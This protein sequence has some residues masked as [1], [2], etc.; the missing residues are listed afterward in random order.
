MASHLFGDVEGREA[1][2]RIDTT[3]RRLPGFAHVDLVEAWVDRQVGSM[4][5]CASRSAA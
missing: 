1:A 3:I 4:P 2:R 5:S